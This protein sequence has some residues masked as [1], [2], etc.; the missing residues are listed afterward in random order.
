M[1]DNCAEILSEKD[2]RR[3]EIRAVLAIGVIASL[4]AARSLIPPGGPI[5][6]TNFSLREILD[7]L[8]VTWTIYIF[9]A[10]VAVSE[11]LFSRIIVMICLNLAQI[12]FGL[13]A[14][15][16]IIAITAI[17]WMITVPLIC[18]GIAYA[19]IKKFIF[20]KIKAKFRKED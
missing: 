2:L 10:A 3:E 1:P 7:G 4:F 6:P 8:I 16:V 5:Y 13:G 17:F 12:I 18:L 15:L 14:L 19:L 11:D 9:L 20:P